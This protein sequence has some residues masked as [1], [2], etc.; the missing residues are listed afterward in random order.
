MKA[1]EWAHGLDL[2]KLPEQKATVLLYAGCLTRYDKK[3]MQSARKLAKLLLH[4]G[5][6]VGILGD[7]EQC[8]GLPA[9]WAGFKDD[10]TDLAEKNAHLFERRA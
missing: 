2:K 5:V 8:C 1:G 10:F 7:D 6:D 3:A 9:H 4:A